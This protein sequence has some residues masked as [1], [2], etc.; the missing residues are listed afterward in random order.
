[1]DNTKGLDGAATDKPAQKSNLKKVW[2]WGLG[3]VAAAAAAAITAHLTGL[4]SRSIDN[5]F[6]QT[7][8]IVTV[9]HEPNCPSVFTAPV[10]TVQQQFDT[11]LQRN[12]SATVADLNPINGNETALKITVQGTSAEKVSLNALELL[13]D[14]RDKPTGIAVGQCGA[15]SPVHFYDA[16]LDSSSTTLVPKASSEPGTA[17]TPVFS[18]NVTSSDPEVFYVVASTKQYD[19]SWHLRLQWSDTK[20]SDT[21]EIDND[22]KPFRTAAAGGLPGYYPNA[23]NRIV[24]LG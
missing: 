7:P 6:P 11:A 10:E 1:M 24:A 17:P 14:K 19:C 23:D 4:F 13:V 3:I 2:G 9:T 21:Y 15:K 12:P 20:R 18:F 22:G 5:V 8:I 16:D